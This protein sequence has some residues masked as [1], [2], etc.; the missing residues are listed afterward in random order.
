MYGGNTPVAHLLTERQRENCRKLA[1]YHYAG[2]VHL[3]PMGFGMDFFCMSHGKKNVDH[4]GPFD[5][6]DWCGTV[7]CVVGH[8]VLAGIPARDDQTSWSE[9]SKN[10]VSLA[11]DSYGDVAPAY[12]T[13]SCLN[14]MVWDWCF[15]AD[16]SRTDNTPEGAAKRIFWMLEFGIPQDFNAQ[17]L[18]VVG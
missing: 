5:V 17:M 8:G 13:P 18:G 4:V 14:L 7:G 3:S 12:A 10:F 11:C 15:S 2:D 16:W 9:Y 1:V 6:P